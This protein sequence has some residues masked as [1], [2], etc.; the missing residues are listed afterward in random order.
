MG[1]QGLIKR[2][3]GAWRA[4][5]GRGSGQSVRSTGAA[6]KTGDTR[7]KPQTW[8]GMEEKNEVIMYHVSILFFFILRF[9]LFIM[10]D[11]EREREAET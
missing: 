8:E 7:S 3:W 2:W 6:G 11:R 1:S 9:Y 4:S 5:T 10:R